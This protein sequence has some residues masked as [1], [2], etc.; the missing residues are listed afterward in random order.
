MLSEDDIRRLALAL[1]GASERA[2]FGGRPSWRTAARMFAWL[3]EDPEALVVWVGSVEDKQALI[4]SDPGTFF[5]T[6]HYDG[7]PMVLVHLDA[8]DE[9]QAA[10]LLVE[11]WILRAPRSLTREVT[12]RGG[13]VST[14]RRSAL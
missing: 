2:S 3:R 10:E 11:S 8:V 12:D 9:Q 5:T 6:S 4:A 7:H 14:I 13:L 1:P